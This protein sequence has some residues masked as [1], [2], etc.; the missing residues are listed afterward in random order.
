MS[1][2]C[3]LELFVQL[4]AT[5]GHLGECCAYWTWRIKGALTLTIVVKWTFWHQHIRWWHQVCKHELLR[6][7]YGKAVSTCLPPDFFL[8]WQQRRQCFQIQL[9]RMSRL[10][11]W[12]FLV[13]GDESVFYLHTNDTS[14]DV[15]DIIQMHKLNIWYHSAR[16]H[17]LQHSLSFGVCGCNSKLLHA[18]PEI[19]LTISVVIPANRRWC[20]MDVLFQQDNVCI[21][22]SNAPQNAPSGMI[23]R[24]VPA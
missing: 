4:R 22:N 14:C 10:I 9:K 5:Y 1:R 11:E 23:A 17:I 15:S 19:N 13:L 8:S 18:H 20:V 16:C 12:G 21:H 6:I 7:I 2:R 24:P 3:R